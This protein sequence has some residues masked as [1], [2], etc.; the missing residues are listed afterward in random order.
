MIHTTQCNSQVL[1]CTTCTWRCS[2]QT[3]CYNGTSAILLETSRDM[4]R[5]GASKFWQSESGCQ[6]M[7]WTWLT[8]WPSSLTGID[9][10]QLSSRAPTNLFLWLAALCFGHSISS[11]TFSLARG[12]PL[13]LPSVD[14]PGTYLGSDILRFATPLFVTVR[15]PNSIPFSS[16]RDLNKKWKEVLSSTSV[17]FHLRAVISYLSLGLAWPEVGASGCWLDRRSWIGIYIG[18]I[19]TV[20]IGTVWDDIDGNFARYPDPPTIIDHPDHDDRP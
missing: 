3:S 10:V 6:Q 20:W 12:S 19:G 14:C 15:R 2:D 13:T 17:F 9:Q 4:S 16:K 5:G 1:A 18:W 8:H 7:S 11:G